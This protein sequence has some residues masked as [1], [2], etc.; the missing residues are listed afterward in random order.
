MDLWL[1]QTEQAHGRV[2]E[3]ASVVLTKGKVSFGT[4]VWF[5][6]IELVN[7]RAAGV[8]STVMVEGRRVARICRNCAR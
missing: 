2:S 1:K 6:R 3:V 5:E 7:E 8:S 4:N